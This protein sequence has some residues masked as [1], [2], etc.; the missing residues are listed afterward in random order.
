MTKL[1]ELKATL[2]AL[3]ARDHD[4]E[5]YDAGRRKAVELGSSDRSAWAKEFDDA[6]D[7]ALRLAGA[8]GKA[9]S[10]LQQAV[11]D[12][13]EEIL[14]D[15]LTGIE[16]GVGMIV[17]I[18]VAA[19]AY[20]AI[21]SMAYLASMIGWTRGFV[22]GLSAAM[23]EQ[24]EAEQDEEQDDADFVGS[25]IFDPD[26]PSYRAVEAQWAAVGAVQDALDEVGDYRAL[27]DVEYAMSDI[28]EAEGYDLG[29]INAPAPAVA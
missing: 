18:D 20:K 21:V 2:G 5:G 3:D 4:D 1:D 6:R 16:L 11:A 13:R 15:G 26:D 7:A 17:N 22:R 9:R 29:A 24:D 25:T 8:F 12:F 14:D 19:R 10:A 23:A 28:E 27:D